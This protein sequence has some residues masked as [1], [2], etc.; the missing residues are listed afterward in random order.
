MDMALGWFFR[1]FNWGF[2]RS[3]DLYTRAVGMLLRVSLIALVVYGGLL[4]LTWWGMSQHAH[5][6]HSPARQGLSAGERAIARRRRGGAH[7][8]R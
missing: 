6:L 3:T 7:P 4:Y 5:R 8:S 1:L 2:S